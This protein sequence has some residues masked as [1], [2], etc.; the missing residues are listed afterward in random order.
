MVLLFCINAC[1]RYIPSP[2]FTIKKL[3]SNTFENKGTECMSKPPYFIASLKRIYASFFQYHQYQCQSSWKE[4]K[5]FVFVWRYAL[6]CRGFHPQI[7][8]VSWS[9]LLVGMLSVL[10]KAEELLYLGGSALLMMI[11][12]P[13]TL[14][15]LDR[16][17]YT[18]SGLFSISRRFCPRIL[19]RPIEL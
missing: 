17:F 9:I 16:H 2:S 14:A 11:V 1:Y 13:H 15:P 4:L 3:L 5:D 8:W 18:S 12:I 6:L 7:G 19:R 10:H